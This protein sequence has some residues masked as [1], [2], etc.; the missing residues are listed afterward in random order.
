[1]PQSQ[2][3]ERAT[4]DPVVH[5]VANAPEEKAPHA[6]RART[7]VVGTDARLLGKECD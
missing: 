1:M 4:V 7:V 2:H 5:E 3:F 6:G